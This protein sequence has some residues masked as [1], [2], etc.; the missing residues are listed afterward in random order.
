LGKTYHIPPGDPLFLACSALNAASLALFFFVIVPEGKFSRAD[1]DRAEPSALLKRL[2][3]PRGFEA[4]GRDGAGEKRGGRFDAL[5]LSLMCL[6]CLLLALAGLGDFKVPERGW[7]ATSASESAI[8]D[9]GQEEYVDSISWYSGIGDGE[10]SIRFSSDGKEW[11]AESPVAP[12]LYSWKN[13]ACGLKARYAQLKPKAAGANILELAFWG[14]EGKA[15]LQAGPSGPGPGSSLVD[16]QALAKAHAGY[17]DS[18]YF[19]EIYFGRTAYEHIHSLEP[20]EWTHPPLGKLIISLGIRLFGMSPFG[21]RVM[22]ALFGVLLVPAF[23]A[24][25]RLAFPTGRLALGAAALYALDFMRYT[26][27]RMGTVDGYVVFFVIASYLFMYRY[28]LSALAKDGTRPDYVSLGLCGLAFGLGAATKWNAIYSG[29]GLAIVFF[30]AFIRRLRADLGDP[31][32]KP[33][34]TWLRA[35]GVVLFC[36]L[37]FILVPIG[38]YVAAYV[39]TLS[40][41]GHDWGSIW[42]YQGQMYNYHSKLVAEHAFSS[43]WWQWWMLVR[44]VWYFKAEGLAA[45][46]T[47]TIVAHGNP[48]IWWPSLACAVAAIFI[49]LKRRDDRFLPI[50]L[51]FFAQYLPWVLVPRLTFLYHYFPAIPFALLCI[52]YCLRAVIPQ[53]LPTLAR[54]GK[55]AARALKASGDGANLWAFLADNWLW[56]YVGSS[57]ILFLWFFPALGGT[58]VPLAW[59]SSLKWLPSWIF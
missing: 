33:P 8:L 27:T 21:W 53:S 56:V 17:M 48:L 31:G 47:S 38:I 10:F 3:D 22:G 45:G 24:L 50:I 4:F 32:R 29:A 46:W 51:G 18:M 14:K 9:L 12:S 23:Y 25:A 42:R 39:P 34:R 52:L 49:A 6:A 57:L 16:E 7:K 5:A 2:A 58:R 43:P 20:Y 59:I 30:I 35:S 44:P 28:Y 15:P 13:Q 55:K 1:R 37:C 40:V 11:S 19:D 26:Q 41:P 36:L 54:G